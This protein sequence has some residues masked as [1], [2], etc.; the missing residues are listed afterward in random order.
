MVCSKYF[1]FFEL[2][3]TPLRIKI[4]EAL[5]NKGELNVTELCKELNEE[6][7]KVSHNLKKLLQC[8]I[9]RVRKVGYYRYYQLNKET[10]LPLLRL[11]DKHVANWCKECKRV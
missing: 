3:S 7:S 8:N 9:V 2:L 11:V 10:I 1:P 6:Q 4:I 5:K